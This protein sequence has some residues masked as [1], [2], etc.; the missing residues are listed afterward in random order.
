MYRNHCT[1]IIISIFIILPT[2]CLSMEEDNQLPIGWWQTHLIVTIDK[3][4]G[5]PQARKA[6][7]QE[8]E[9]E[10]THSAP[11]AKPAAEDNPKLYFNY[12][13]DPTEQKHSIH[14]PACRAH[15]STSVTMGTLWW[16]FKNHLQTQTH[17]DME[18]YIKEKLIQKFRQLY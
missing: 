3:Y 12:W 15:L 10:V 8:P 2:S 16:L 7:Y 4:S 18:P 6:I 13:F 14:C 9:N 11:C 17:R 5:V 1:K